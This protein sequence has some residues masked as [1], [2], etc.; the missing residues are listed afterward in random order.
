MVLK[1]LTDFLKGII[2]GI[3]AVAPGVSG[4]TFAVVLGVYSRLTNAIAN[5][6]HDFFR[7][8]RMLFPLGMGIV[9]GVLAFSRV[10]KYLFE[11]HETNIKFLFI[12]LML[13]TIPLVIKDANKKGFKKSYLMPCIAAFSMTLSF[14]ILEDNVIDV[15]PETS[16]GLLALIVYGVIIGFGTIVPGVSSSFILMFIGAY[17]TLLDALVS[18]DLMIIIPVGIGFGLSILL[19]A[20]IINYLFDK[21][22][23]FTYYAILGF[24]FGSMI[25]IIPRVELRFEIVFGIIYC[26]IGF[27][28]TYTMS[29][30]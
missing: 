24:V 6:F 14:T 12:G 22:Y 11:Y 27:L 10:M 9:F 7:K 19:F 2:I 26:I 15:I 3:G 8:V 13:G 1:F 20:K 16:P 25:A 4:G 5:V 21:I 28:F 23:G 17:G 30:K 29:R 18:L